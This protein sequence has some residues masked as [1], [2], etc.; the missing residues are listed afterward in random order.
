MLMK[1][2]ILILRFCRDKFRIRFKLKIYRDISLVH[3]TDVLI[4]MNN[5]IYK[6]LSTNFL[7]RKLL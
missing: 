3:S 5:N 1:Y 6:K 7:T 4:K 2:K